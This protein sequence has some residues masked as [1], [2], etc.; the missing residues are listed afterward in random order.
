MEICIAE[1]MACLSAP[2]R[3]EMTC[4]SII[5]TCNSLLFK[6]SSSTLDALSSHP[7]NLKPIEHIWCTESELT[8]SVDYAP[9]LTPRVQQEIER[10]ARA[11]VLDSI[12]IYS[13]V[14][15]EPDLVEG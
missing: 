15:V 3:L 13:Y 6:P 12:I 9:R 8:S 5:T 2:G 7:V 4:D 14:K 11:Y 10:G 1:K